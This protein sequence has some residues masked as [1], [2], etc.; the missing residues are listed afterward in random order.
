M[1][2]RKATKRDIS[3]IVKLLANDELGKTR[4]SYQEPLPESY[5]IAFQNIRPLQGKLCKIINKI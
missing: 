5:Y 2:F 3:D 4:E 1:I